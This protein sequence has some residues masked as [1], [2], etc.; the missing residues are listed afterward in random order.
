VSSALRAYEPFGVAVGL[1]A[2]GWDLDR[3]YAGVGEDG[4][5][6]GDEL[7]GPVAY[8]EPKVLCS[9]PRSAT[10]VQACG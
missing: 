2:S 3:L 4:V 5:E 7:S 1:P 9:S 8:Q 6:G 10:R